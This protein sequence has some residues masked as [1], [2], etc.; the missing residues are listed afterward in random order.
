MAAL[1]SGE[2]VDYDPY[3]PWVGAFKLMLAMAATFTGVDVSIYITSN[4]T[5]F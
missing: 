3:L 4:L 2:S 1:P 5:N